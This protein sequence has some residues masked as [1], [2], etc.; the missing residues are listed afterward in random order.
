MAEPKTKA[1]RRAEAARQDADHEAPTQEG[2][3]R[4]GRERPTKAERRQRR[5]ARKQKSPADAVGEAD[6]SSP[7]TDIE[8]RLARIEEAV[9]SQSERSEE[10]LGKLDEVLHEARK[11]ARL[12]KSAAAP[13]DDEAG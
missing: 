7:Q 8:S 5:G 11:S 12:A 9:A 1:E 6:A 3:P 13:P 4:G 2:D 10:L